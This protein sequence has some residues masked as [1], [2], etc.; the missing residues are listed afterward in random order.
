[1]DIPISDFLNKII[2]WRDF[3]HFVRDLYLEGT[4]VEVRHNVTEIGKSGATRQIDVLIYQKVQ[5]HTLK[6]IVE[7]KFW[8]SKVD[9]A[10]ID[11]VFAALDDLT[12]NKGVIFTTVG[13]EL[14]AELYAKS[15]GIDI[16]V[17][18]DLSKEEW[19]VSGR[20]MEFFLQFFGSEFRD[21]Q[22]SIGNI[23]KPILDVNKPLNLNL[24]FGLTENQEFPE[25]GNLYKL[26]ENANFEQ[27]NHILKLLI[28][29]RNNLLEQ[30]RDAIHGV[31]APKEIKHSYYYAQQ[32]T[33]NFENYPNRFLKVENSF[34]ELKTI[35]FDYIYNIS[36]NYML[37]DRAQKYDYVLIVE[38]YI[39]KG[40]SFVAK[41]KS[42]N[43]I[44]ITEYK[45]FSDIPEEEVLTSQSVVKIMLEPF[46][47][48]E[49]NSQTEIIRRP[50]I[51]VNVKSKA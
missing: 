7:C 30:I 22:L 12:A 41:E 26:L 44:E 2:D 15:K 4:G 29:I 37:F 50:P 34:I 48:L 10:I 35:S 18:R 11:I 33:I 3:E 1:M 51:T 32:C 45:D 27:N 9:R 24:Q 28:E 42:K 43:G 40:R 17:V 6:I 5:F 47:S 8:T 31:F 23:H 21:F 19:G 20:K 39:T 36:Q 16:F 46:V 14:G 25:S 13:Y 49:I 38:D